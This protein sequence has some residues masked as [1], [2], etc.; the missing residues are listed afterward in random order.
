M[1]QVFDTKTGIE[2]MRFVN[3][4]GSRVRFSQNSE[5][6]FLPGRVGEVRCLASN[7][8]SQTWSD[9]TISI[10]FITYF[11]LPWLNGSNTGNILSAVAIEQHTNEY[12][13]TLFSKSGEV[14]AIDNFDS[15]MDISPN[16][17]FTI[18][19]KYRHR[20]DRMVCPIVIRKILQEGQIR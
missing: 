13:T 17:F 11:S 7:N 9:Q 3:P 14:L 1:L 6:L 19:E 10:D 4:F 20:T 12:L 16:G 18:T 5:I 15:M 8:G 2:L